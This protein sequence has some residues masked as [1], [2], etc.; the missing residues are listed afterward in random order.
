MA[1]TDEMVCFSLY[2]AARATTQAY[3]ALLA[4]WG[5]TYP[6]YL[7][8]AIL[9]HEGDQTIGS[10][11]DAMQLDSGTLSPLVRR[12]ELAGHVARARRSDDER[13]VTVA[14]T[15]SGHALRHDLASIPAQVARFSGIRDDAHRRRLIAELQELTAL[16]QDATTDAA[17][18]ARSGA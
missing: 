12:L 14:L 10:L 18:H 1:V 7:V 11:G 6:Q 9:W 15:P 5:L 3:R 17:T 13:V 16:L 8:L 2:S 4:P